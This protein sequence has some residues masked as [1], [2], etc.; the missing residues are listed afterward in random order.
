MIGS[1]SGGSR[2]E[3]E[4]RDKRPFAVRLIFKRSRAARSNDSGEGGRV[5]VRVKVDKGMV[6]VCNAVVLLELGFFFFA[7]PCEMDA[8]VRVK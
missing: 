3:R 6:H 4:G 1:E 2:G 7:L 8:R 5:T